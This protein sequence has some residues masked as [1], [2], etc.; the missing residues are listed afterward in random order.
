M[1]KMRNSFRILIGKREGKSLI[2]RNTRMIIIIQFS[3]INLFTCLTT[4]KNGQLQ[5]S[6]NNN[7]NNNNTNK[8]YLEGK[9]YECVNWIH[10]SQDR[11]PLL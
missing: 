1:V 8:V 5:P 2:V 9:G 7:N 10:L 6:T 3:S 11:D 4:A